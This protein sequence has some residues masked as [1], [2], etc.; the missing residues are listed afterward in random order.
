MTLIYIRGDHKEPEKRKPI[1]TKIIAGML[2]TA[3][4]SQVQYFLVG[5][6]GGVMQTPFSILKGRFS[7][8]KNLNK[9]K[10]Y[11]IK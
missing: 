1:P 10:L 2:E 5:G 6:G 8:F 3:G 9:I 7:N 4:T 11:G